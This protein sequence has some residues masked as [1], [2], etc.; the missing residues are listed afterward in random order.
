MGGAM[1]ITEYMTSSPIT[2]SGLTSLPEARKIL[3]E[4]RIRH[5]PVIDKQ[6]RL[7]G[8]LTDRD[9]RSAYPSS[10][11]TKE[12]ALLAFDRVQQST[13]EDIMTTECST[14]TIDARLEDALLIFERDKVGAIPVVDEDDKVIGLFSLLDLTSAYGSLFGNSSDGAFCVVIEDDGRE[15]IFTQLSQL[16]DKNNIVLKGL[17]QINSKKDV[18]KIYMR[19]N[20]LK[21]GKVLKLLH[22]QNYHLLTTMR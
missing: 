10:V 14:L 5:L 18:A 19:V 15:N 1:Y 6:D 2:V 17:M 13:A 11:T 22:S 8:I 20:S 12:E 9:L 21:P 16:C 7:I 3:A 4:Y